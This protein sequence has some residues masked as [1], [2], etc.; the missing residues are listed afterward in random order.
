MA[1]VALGGITPPAP[2]APYPRSGGIVSLRFPPTFIPTTPWS[3][4][5]ITSRAPSVN[6]NGL[7][8]SLEESNFLP[9]VSQPV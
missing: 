9:L 5:G 6:V 8:W 4:P 7:P 3:Q 2:R 1:S